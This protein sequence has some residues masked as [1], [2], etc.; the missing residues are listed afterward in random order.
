MVA[1]SAALGMGLTATQAWASA[2]AVVPT[3]T[4]L[5]V[6]TRDVAGRTVAVFTATA[7]ARD[8]RA[9]GGAVTLVEKGKTLAGAAL[10][11]AGTAQIEL[12]GLPA[13]DHLIQAV[14]NGDG[15]HAV[16]KS[17]SLAVHPLAT[18]TPD[19]VLAINPASLTVAAPGASANLGLTVTPVNGFTGFISLSCSGTG[20]TTT[21]PVGVTCTFAPAN[22]QVSAPTT[23]NPSG[24]ASAAMGLQTSTGQ[25][26]TR[27]ERLGASN[28]GVALA[29]LLPGLAGLGFAARK[30]KMLRPLALLLMVGAVSVL[31]TTAC[32][33][34][35]GYLH[36]GPV[37]G[38]TAAGSYTINVT[39]QTSNGVTAVSHNVPLA[40]TVK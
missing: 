13:G 8:G 22:L 5:T 1:L 16:S 38:G 15:A 40:L 19:F 21:L 24:T 33:A 2:E 7:T 29:V 32:S 3:D 26:T 34:R 17:E 10:S 25:Q 39:A 9:P 31:G 14:Y 36:H 6:E 11:V 18:A 37:F 28:N 23:S 35:Y 4:R 30:R 12:D 27:L 20:A